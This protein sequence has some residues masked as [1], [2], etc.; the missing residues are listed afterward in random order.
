[1]SYIHWGLFIL[2][3][4]KIFLKSKLALIQGKKRGNPQHENKCSKLTIKTQDDP[5]GEYL[6]SVNKSDIS[7]SFYIATETNGCEWNIK[8]PSPLSFHVASTFSKSPVKILEN[9][10]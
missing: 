10:L 3:H 6:F 8:M 9:C 5:V 1:M 7:L 2:S 4:D